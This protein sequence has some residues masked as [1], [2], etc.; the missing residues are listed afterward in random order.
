MAPRAGLEPA[1]RCLEGSRSIQLSYRGEGQKVTEI[2]GLAEVVGC[3][4]FSTAHR[5]S[6][7]VAN[8]WLDLIAATHSSDQKAVNQQRINRSSHHSRR[9]I[10]G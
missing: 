8:L 9:L 3:S 2:Q 1:T 10:H 4:L 7:I 5:Y 6:R